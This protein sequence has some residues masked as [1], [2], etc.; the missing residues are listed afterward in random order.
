MRQTHKYTS[1]H[2]TDDTGFPLVWI[3]TRFFQKRAK[4]AIEQEAEEYHQ[5][6]RCRGG[7]IIGRVAGPEAYVG[8]SAVRRQEQ[9]VTQA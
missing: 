9:K 7:K 3:I 8:Q 6:S 2:Y 5:R 4:V 1:S